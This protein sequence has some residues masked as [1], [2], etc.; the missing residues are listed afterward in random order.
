MEW[1]AAKYKGSKSFRIIQYAPQNIS[2]QQML[3]LLISLI[4]M[5]VS[6][7]CKCTNLSIKLYPAIE[8]PSIGWSPVKGHCIYLIDRFVPLQSQETCM[9]IKPKS[10][11]RIV[12]TPRCKW[13][14]W[15]LLV[16][17]ECVYHSALWLRVIHFKTPLK[18]IK[19]PWHIHEIHVIQHVHVQICCFRLSFCFSSC[20]YPQI[21]I[22][23]T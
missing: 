4:D 13:D 14:I 23:T 17:L 21:K 3:Q 11:N 20:Q 1:T 16:G 19:Y 10:T 15:F 22:A 7:D 8:P 9:S 5:H 12:I 2:T 6:C 18:I